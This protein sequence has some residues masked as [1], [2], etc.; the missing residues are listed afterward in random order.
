MKRYYLA[1]FLLIAPVN[2]WAVSDGAGWQILIEMKNSIK[3]LMDQVKIMKQGLDLYRD[4]QMISENKEKSRD[5]FTNPLFQKYVGDVSALD[6]FDDTYKTV[7]ELEEIDSLIDDLDREIARTQGKDREYWQRRKELYITYRNLSVL[8][9]ANQSN[10]NKSGK[11]NAERDSA[12]LTANATTGLYQIE[13]E[14]YQ[15]ENEQERNAMDSE[16]MHKG[17]KGSLGN[18]YSALGNASVSTVKGQ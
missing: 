8:R 11:N 6:G 15:K 16:R 4:M 12:N 13:I 7:A 5:V 17:L 10:F 1:I 2:T 18:A 14:R 3:L 9:R